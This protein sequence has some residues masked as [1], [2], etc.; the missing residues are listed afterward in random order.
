MKPKI[1]I[2]ARANSIQPSGRPLNYKDHLVRIYG[3]E[4][5]PVVPYHL[6]NQFGSKKDLR[7]AVAE[8]YLVILILLGDF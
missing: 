5:T 6:E 3:K 4:A 7:K 2:S 8:A 1:Y